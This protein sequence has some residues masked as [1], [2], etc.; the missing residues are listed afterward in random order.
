MGI[1]VAIVNEQHEP[2]HAV[3]DPHQCLTSLA[4]CQWTHLE[5]SVC[6]R[7]VDPWGDTVF[8]QAQIPV[9]LAEL[10]NSASLQQDPQ[11]K[12]H[13]HLVCHLVAEARDKVH[14]YIKF[15]GD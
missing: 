12:A 11:I 13:L 10:E 9:L 5:G 15:I 3:Y 6:L 1:D 4:A 2:E 14:T 7:F 8:N